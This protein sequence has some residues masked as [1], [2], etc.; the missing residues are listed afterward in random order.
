MKQNQNFDMIPKTPAG[1]SIYSVTQQ[2]P[3]HHKGF[4]E[5]IYCLKGP[6]TIYTRLQDITLKEGDIISCDPFDIHY[7]S[8]DRENLLVSF[9]FDLTDPVFEKPDLERIYF[10]C[11]PLTTP[12]S[13][14]PELQNLKRLLL[15]MLYF[16]CFPHPGLSVS[17]IITR[18][19]VEVIQMMLNHFHYFYFIANSTEYSDEMKDR[20]ESIIIYIDK[21]YSKKITL[22]KLCDIN[23]FNYKYLSRFFKKTSFVG[24]SKFVNDIR[25]YKAA[26]LLLET[27]KNISDIAYE[28]GF[29]S[30][31]YY[32][33]VFEKWN[34]TTPNRYRRKLHE[35]KSSAKETTYYNVETKKE[36]LEHFI[37]FHFA[38]LQVPEL[39]LSPFVPYKGL[40]IE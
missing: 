25:A 38:K 27:D 1:I 5:I 37:A 16:Y 39:W 40:P 12:Q 28:V 31:L 6:V 9:Y 14:Q 32:Y 34:V 22:K 4:L 20:F 15:T 2:A 21:N 7:L 35:L 24:F 29:S 30:P 18:F 33:R 13:K 19:A 26:S 8:C 10:I 11:E 17:N 36:D 23:H 3:H